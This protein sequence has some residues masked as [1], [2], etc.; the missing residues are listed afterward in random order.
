MRF[1]CALADAVTDWPSTFVAGLRTNG[2]IA[3]VVVDGAMNGNIF[4]AYVEQALAPT[5]KP[6]DIVILGQS[7]R[8]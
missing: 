1:G 4:R 2:L 8:R 7:Y 3:P 6:G 5:L